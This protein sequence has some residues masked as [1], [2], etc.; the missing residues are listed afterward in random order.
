M[1][2]I[3]RRTSAYFGSRERPCE[4][5]VVDPALSEQPLSPD[6]DEW[7]RAW[8]I[9]IAD[10]EALCALA[11]SAG[12]PII[13]KAEHYLHKALPELEIYDDYRE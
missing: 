3:V 8:T 6:D 7:D 1:K 12:S 4:G 10:L 13:L 2:F 11:R 5:A 9:E